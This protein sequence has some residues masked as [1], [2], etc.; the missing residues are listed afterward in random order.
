MPRTEPDAEPKLLLEDYGK[1]SQRWLQTYAAARDVYKRA[2]LVVPDA[3]DSG[4]QFLI[5]SGASRTERWLERFARQKADFGPHEAPPN[6]APREAPELHLLLED[7]SPGPRFVQEIGR[8]LSRNGAPSAA[9][10]SANGMAT[11]PAS[12]AKSNT[13]RGGAGHAESGEPK[14]PAPQKAAKTAWAPAAPAK[15]DAEDLDLRLELDWESTVARQQRQRSRTPGRTRDSVAAA[16]R[17]PAEAAG[18]D[19]AR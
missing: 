19:S 12:I 18:G 4:V 16:A 7:F 9:A 1:S 10:E 11:T 8:L 3:R 6:L 13:P 2:S 17:H 5:D 15:I 14:K